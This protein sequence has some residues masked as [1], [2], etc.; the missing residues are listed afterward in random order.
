MARGAGGAHASVSRITLWSPTMLVP[1]HVPLHRA[2]L[3][4]A[5][6]CPPGESGWG[7]GFW[8]CHPLQDVTHCRVSS[9][10]VPLRCGSCR[11]LKDSPPAAPLQQ[12]KLQSWREGSHL[13]CAE[14]LL[15][16]CHSR[17]RCTEAQ[18][19][20]GVLSCLLHYSSLTQHL[21]CELPG[22]AGAPGHPRG[23][24]CSAPLLCLGAFGLRVLVSRSGA[25][26]GLCAGGSTRHRG[27]DTPKVIGA[28]SGSGMSFVLLGK[29]RIQ[30]NTPLSPQTSKSSQSD[31]LSPSCSW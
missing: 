23:S 4:T 17:T 6:S 14:M 8:G 26:G 3:G 28:S 30:Q 1:L 29:S 25:C 24:Q 31:A 10:K 11:V 16:L 19:P 13:L 22:A 12:R 18:P 2:L 27:G 15:Q 20:A 7:S 21:G 9:S 5:L